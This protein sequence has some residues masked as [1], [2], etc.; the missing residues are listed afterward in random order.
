MYMYIEYLYFQYWLLFHIIIFHTCLY[1]IQLSL[2]GRLETDLYTELSEHTVQ[3]PARLQLYLS[4]CK[5][6]DTAV[7]L[8]PQM[9]PHFQL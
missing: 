7:A 9:L 1:S 6:L 5:L 3:P 2:L 4:V 8:P